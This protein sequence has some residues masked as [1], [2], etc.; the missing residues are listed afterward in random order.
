MS[1]AL[2]PIVVL[3]VILAPDKKGDGGRG[4]PDICDSLADPENRDLTPADWRRLSDFTQ[5]DLYAYVFER[6]P[7]HLEKV[8]EV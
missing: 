5:R 3:A 1:A 2:V 7:Q 8:I 6:C 4:N